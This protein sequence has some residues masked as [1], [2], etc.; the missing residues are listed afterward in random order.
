MSAD[1]PSAPLPAHVKMPALE[2]VPSRRSQVVE[3]LRA[4][5]IS[6][7]MQPGVVY[8]A[9]ALAAQFGVSPTPVREAMMHLANEGLIAVARNKGFRVIEP[10]DR[11]LDEILELR[12]L[13]EVPTVGRIAE[14]GADPRALAH[15]QELAGE[16]VAAARARDITRHIT[17]DIA[18]H[19]ALLALAGNAQLVAVVS[20]LRS[21]S[22][23]FGLAFPERSNWLLAI[24]EEHVRIVELVGARDADGARRLMREHLA[25]VRSEWRR[26]A[27]A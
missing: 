7:E 22:R 12:Q 4:A 16:T 9:P 20:A 14:E 13:L 5:I 27:D 17:A 15:A 1:V 11:D 19:S 24:S 18:F 2:R 21:K 26:D 8:S 23:L 3:T 6:G 10:S 25:H